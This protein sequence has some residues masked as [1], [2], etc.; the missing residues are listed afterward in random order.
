MHAV[1]ANAVDFQAVVAKALDE[2]QVKF[3]RVLLGFAN[4]DH[5]PFDAQLLKKLQIFIAGISAGLDGDLNAG[6]AGSITG[7]RPHGKLIGCRTHCQYA[8][9]LG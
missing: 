4:A 2:V 6:G 1:V 3:T 7:H 9:F 5:G 8:P